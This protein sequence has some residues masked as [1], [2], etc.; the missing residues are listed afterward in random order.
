M[1]DDSGIKRQK[2]QLRFQMKQ[3]LR[4]TSPTQR[5]RCSAEVR[6]QLACQLQKPQVI[7][8]YAG[9]WQEP[10]LDPLWSE[11]L[12]AHRLILYPRLEEQELYFCPISSLDQLRLGRFGIREPLTSPTG[13]QP[14]VILVPGLAFGKDRSRLGRGDGFYDRLLSKLAG[15]T[16]KVGVGFEFQLLDSLPVE[17]HDSWLDEI[18]VG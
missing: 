4:A 3:L 2:Q 18:I 15:R 16:R 5:E 14:D 10:N 7:A 8:L 6:H 11:G 13:E 9:T 17:P 12:F 1:T